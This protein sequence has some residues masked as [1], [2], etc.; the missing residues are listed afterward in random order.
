MRHLGN[1]GQINGYGGYASQGKMTANE[2]NTVEKAATL[3]NTKQMTPQQ[4]KRVQK[5]LSNYGVNAVNQMP[6]SAWA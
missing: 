2:F 1:G 4:A 3:L 5:N 6:A